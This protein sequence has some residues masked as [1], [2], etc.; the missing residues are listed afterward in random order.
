L[1]AQPG[2]VVWQGQ[3]A[4][5]AAFERILREQTSAAPQLNFGDLP[6]GRYTLRVRAADARG[7]HGQDA[8]HAFELDA[9]PFPPLVAGPGARVRAPRPV[10]QWTPVVGAE[11]YRVE[12]ARDAGFADPV[13]ATRTTDSR[14]QPVTDLVPGTYYWRVASIDSDGPGPFAPPQRVVYDPLPD[15]PEL[16]QAAP[17]FADGGLALALPPPPAGLHYELVLS[18]DAERQQV[19]WQG[20]SR[21]GQMRAERVERVDHH[22]GARLVEADGTAGPWAT[23][24]IGAPPP[25]RWPALLFLLPLLL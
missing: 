16:A 25:P 1:P 7:L 8:L 11:A 17:L 5:D 9:R 3:I 22:L 10:L 12:L 6:D 21:D 23:R 14:Q 24:V 20:T 13:L 18:A 4:P 19:I 15:A 2:A